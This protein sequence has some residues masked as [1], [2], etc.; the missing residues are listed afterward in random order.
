MSKSDPAFQHNLVGRS[1]AI[2]NVIRQAAEAARNSSTVLV[3]GETGTGKELV[4]RAIHSNGARAGGPFVAMN[5][6]AIPETLFESEL[7][8]HEKGAFTGAVD[9]KPGEFELA[10]GGTLFLDEVGELPLLIQA[11]LLRVLQEREF[12]SLGGRQPIKADVRIIAATNRDLRD[13]F[14]QDLYYRLNVISI[15]T[16]PL[17]ERLDDILVLAWHF[18]SIYGPQSPRRVCAISMAAANALESHDWPGNVRELQN[19]IERAVMMGSS[20]EILPEDL[21]DFASSLDLDFEAGVAAAQRSLLERAFALADGHV[22]T[23][24]A[25]LRLNR[26]YVYS[27]LKKFN[28]MHLRRPINGPA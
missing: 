28:L 1:A 3:V 12:K 24:S 27:L 21:P 11:K 16:P 8:G 26:N 15:R 14:R 6:A 19:V 13:R 7:F 22:D 10:A 17:R 25:L 2:M 5:C 20:N 9:R 23:A 4:A 18:L